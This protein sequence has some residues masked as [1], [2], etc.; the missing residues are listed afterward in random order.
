MD[1]PNVFEKAYKLIDE[2]KYAE[3]YK[4]LK[5]LGSP[6]SSDDLNNLLGFTARKSGNLDAASRYYAAALEINP[7]HVGALQY[8]GE[9]FITLGQVDKA[10]DNLERIGKIC[11]LFHVMKSNYWKKLLLSQLVNKSDPN[12]ND[13]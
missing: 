2:K 3:A 10:K 11:W 9:L 5:S 8:Q 6:G 4:E 1:A 7:K 12:F 13:P